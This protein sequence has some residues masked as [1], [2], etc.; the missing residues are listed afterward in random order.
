[1]TALPNTWRWWYASIADWMLANPNLTLAECA[2][3]FGK[4]P[5]TISRIV[6][7]DIYKAYF[8]QRRKEFESEHA[9]KITRRLGD[10]V[11]KSID[12]IEEK[13]EK[14]R[15]SVPLDVLSDLMGSS[16]EALGFGKPAAPAVQLNQYNDH[17]QT[18]TLPTTVTPMALEE[19]RAAIR[20]VE[21][22]QIEA[23][24][25]LPAPGAA[26]GSVEATVPSVVGAP[27]VETSEE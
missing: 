3:Y 22:R 14:K 24:D 11:L 19:A 6:N 20:R 18:V 10:V 9:A 12:V 13:L 16:L 21:A 17:S 26:A 4:N 1:M 8:A 27:V 5:N 2:V 15:D 7:S 25:L 23:I